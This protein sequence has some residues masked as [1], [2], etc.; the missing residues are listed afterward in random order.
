VLPLQY[1]D[2]DSFFSSDELPTR[3]TNLIENY[4]Y[5]SPY[6]TTIGYRRDEKT[7]LIHPIFE[8]GETDTSLVNLHVAVAESMVD[9]LN[10]V[11]FSELELRRWCMA[12]LRM[13]DD[14]NIPID[15]TPLDGR[16]IRKLTCMECI[17]YAFFGCSFER[18]AVVYSVGFGLGR[19]LIALNRV[20]DKARRLIY[21]SFLKRA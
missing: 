15:L 6:Q 14:M 4:F 9:S 16:V 17:S 12:L 2:W 19:I 10:R 1:G 11:P 8:E 13:L 18:T 7:S 3:L 5:I 21:Q 20:S